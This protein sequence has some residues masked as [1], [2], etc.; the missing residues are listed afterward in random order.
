MFHRVREAML[1][2]PLAGML[3]QGGG[4]VELDETYV[5]GKKRNNLHANRMA[6]AGRKT[7]VMTLIDREGEAKAVVVPNTRKGTLQGY[8]AYRG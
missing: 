1:Q 5:G 2:E 6:D 4:I 3:G 7:A 8:K